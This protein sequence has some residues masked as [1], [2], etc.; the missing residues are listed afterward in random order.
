[1]STILLLCYFVWITIMTFSSKET[2]LKAVVASTLRRQHFLGAFPG[3]QRL[4]PVAAF[5]IGD[6]VAR[7]SQSESPVERFLCGSQNDQAELSKPAK[8]TPGLARALSKSTIDCC[9]TCSS[10]Q[11]RTKLSRNISITAAFGAFSP[12]S[13]LRRAIL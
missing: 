4:L 11:P 1:M 12:V 13:E 7:S 3:A 5:A 2:E 10:P 6:L 8:Q 9:L